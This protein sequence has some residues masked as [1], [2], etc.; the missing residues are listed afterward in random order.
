MS[1]INY[2]PL[3]D[4]L[5]K[6]PQHIELIKDKYLLLLSQL[7]TVS[8]MDDSLFK[9]NVERINEIGQII[10]G[11]IGE[12]KNSTN[13]N[14]N[15]DFKIVASGTII[16]EPKIIRGGKYV[17]HIEDIVVLKEMRGNNIS[18][19]ILDLLKVHAMYNN[20]YKVILDCKEELKNFYIKNGFE[21]KGIQ[22]SEY[23]I[24]NV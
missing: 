7:T 22:M 9:T 4:L 21:V 16:F 8:Y 17:G 19:T 23:F 1:E 18:K 6:Y 12:L 24:N 10:V 11:I 14:T 13:T 5:N 2:I 20:C 15:N 3:I